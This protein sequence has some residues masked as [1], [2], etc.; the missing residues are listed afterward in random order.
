MKPP[1]TNDVNILQQGENQLQA[2]LAKPGNEA[3][4]KLSSSTSTIKSAL[5][6]S[7]PSLDVA[8][9]LKQ[10]TMTPETLA[11]GKGVILGVLDKM[12]VPAGVVPAPETKEN[13][14]EQP[15][16]EDGRYKNVKESGNLE[17]N[18]DRVGKYEVNHV[19]WY[20]AE[21]INSWRFGQR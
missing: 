3:A 12:K 20:K 2:F 15:E 8:V 14:N 9:P 7:Q 13:Q 11:K 16:V 1:E 19:Y 18:A 10:P 6:P 4:L 17:Q 21:K 5:K